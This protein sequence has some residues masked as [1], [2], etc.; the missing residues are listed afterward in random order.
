MA[1]SWACDRGYCGAH[2]SLSQGNPC[3]PDCPHCTAQLARIKGGAFP[4]ILTSTGIT[5][6]ESRIR[7]QITERMIR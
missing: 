3:R 1:V 5:D 4:V 6:M 7:Y 2:A